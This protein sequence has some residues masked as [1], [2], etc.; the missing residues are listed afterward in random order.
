MD[1][2]SRHVLLA[3]LL[4]LFVNFALTVPPGFDPSTLAYLTPGVKWWREIGDECSSD[5]QCQPGT[6]CVNT[7][8]N[9]PTCRHRS[10]IG[11]G[12]SLQSYQGVYYGHCPCRGR[13]LCHPRRRICVALPS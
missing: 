12:C 3:C 11:H 13:A 7:G 5:G 9:S 2:E 8:L 6:C 4:V 10:R 1:R